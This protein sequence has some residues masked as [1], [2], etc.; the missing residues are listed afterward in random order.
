MEK[1]KKL[2]T[3][4]MDKI[5]S[6]KWP[7]KKK[8]SE[9]K[10]RAL[11]FKRREHK[12]LRLPIAISLIV[13]MLLPVTS[14][15]IYTYNR[16]TSILTE[17]VEAQ[18][19]QI[20]A[21][22]VNTITDAGIAAE[23]TIKRLSI[24]GVL[25]RVATDGEERD[26]TDLISRF[27][28]VVTGNPY[29]ADVHFV[30]ANSNFNFVSTLSV[31]RGDQ[32][33]YEIFPWYESGLKASGLRWTDPH[34]YN[35]RTRLT[36]TRAIGTGTNLQ[37]VLAIDLDLNVIREEINQT[38]IANTGYISILDDN[39]TVVASSQVALVGENLSSSDFFQQSQSQSNEE[40]DESSDISTFSGMV[41]DKEIN[42]GDFGIYYERIPN[43]GLNVYGQVQAHEMENETSTLQLIAFVVVVFT[44]IIAGVVALLAS[45][46][47]ASITEALM[48]AFKRTEEGDLTTRLTKN[49]LINP[50]NA[51]VKGLNKWHTRKGSKKKVSKKLNP[52]GNEIHQIGLAFNKTL[53]TFEETVKVIQGNSQNVSS[54]A[55]TL[56]EIADQTSRATSE[57]SQTINGVAESTSMQTQDT[58]ATVHQM[59]EL[60]A[61]LNEIDEAVA[62]MGTQADKTMIVNGNNARSIQEVNEKWNETLKT[63]DDLKAIIEEVDGDIQNIE[64]IVKVITN[65]AS[66][67]NLLALNASIEAARAGDAGRGFAVVAEE[68]RKLAEQSTG[69]SKDIQSIIQQIQ[70]KSS[71][72]VEHLE[73]TDKDSLVQTEKIKEAIGASED[74][75]L[76]LE[77]LVASMLVVMNASNVISEKKEEVV[78][79]L[80]SIAAGSQENSAG[81]EQ[82]SAN[83]EEILAT[84]EEFTT[85]I[86]QLENVASILK[87]SAEQFL[88]E[89]EEAREAEEGLDDLEPEF[90]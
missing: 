36:V 81:T 34:V 28:Y 30:P 80:E 54:M 12:S 5:K 57:V 66:R 68:I 18:E 15:M 49:E 70:D 79:Q 73:E 2:S 76:S 62:K 31:V 51:I 46:L 3:Q 84:M 22:L 52:K 69:S 33:P 38:Q 42:N 65:I 88:I 8:N 89:Q 7:N 11:F 63:I 14:A 61:A 37:G 75:A 25:S 41:Y 39:G 82:V 40:A 27:Q 17:R 87:E 64:G 50:A 32:D 77:Q 4:L 26:Q 72:M 71:S 53:A 56:T 58:E 85:H 29:I 90:A 6:I 43:L 47:I 78:A 35:N 19:Q 86:N 45:G 24:D 20:T 23:E 55:T 10:S 9:K 67:T 74:V 1:I 60:S 59:N 16:T 44:I 83:A 48:R 21:N 13:L